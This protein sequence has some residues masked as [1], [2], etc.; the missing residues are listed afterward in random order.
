MDAPYILISTIAPEKGKKID[1]FDKH[2]H[3]IFVRSF[4][5]ILKMYHPK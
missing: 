1:W 4:S 2:M 5:I 3:I